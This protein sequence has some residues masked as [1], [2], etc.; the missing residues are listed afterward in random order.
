[1]ASCTDICIITHATAWEIAHTLTQ[2]KAQALAT[3]QTGWAHRDREDTQ[4]AM[5]ARL[6][7]PW[8]THGQP[9]APTWET[10]GGG[11]RGLMAQTKQ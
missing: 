1:M 5:G 4:H 9:E 6:S 11:R 3:T 10:E 2:G 8:L 7:L